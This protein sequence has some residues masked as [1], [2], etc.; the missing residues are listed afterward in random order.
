MTTDGVVAGGV[1]VTGCGG[2]W[3][4]RMVSRGV[5]TDGGGC[6]SLR[7]PG[8]VAVRGGKGGRGLDGLG[9]SAALGGLSTDD[10]SVDPAAT[11]PAAEARD[12]DGDNDRGDADRLKP[13][14]EME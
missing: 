12:C 2:D 1:T 5:A 14:G 10:L 13:M 7:R 11:A 8:E 6:C 3:Q 9:L 4:Q